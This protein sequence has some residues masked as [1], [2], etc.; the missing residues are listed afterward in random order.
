LD[1][2]RRKISLVSGSMRPARRLAQIVDQ[3]GA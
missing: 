1:N 3:L 2:E